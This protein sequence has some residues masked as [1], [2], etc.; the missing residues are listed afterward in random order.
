MIDALA[1][2]QIV[3]KIADFAKVLRHFDFAIFAI[4]CNRLDQL[5]LHALHFFRVVSVHGVVGIVIVAKTAWKR[6]VATSWND[7]ALAAVVLAAEIVF[8]FVGVLAERG[9]RCWRSGVCRWRWACVTDDRL[10]G[11][12]ASLLFATICSERCTT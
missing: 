1:I 3:E 11:S 10:I 4:F 5:A 2:L 8:V 12:V 6:N 9:Q 7:F